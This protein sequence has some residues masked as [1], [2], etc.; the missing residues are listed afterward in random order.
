MNAM[1]QTLALLLV[2]SQPLAAMRSIHVQLTA[3]TPQSTQGG[4]SAAAMP[5]APSDEQLHQELRD[6]KAAMEQALNRRDVDALLAHVDERVVFTTMN[7][8]VVT[9]RDGVR[10]YF[11]R[12]MNGP[13]KIVE[14]VQ[15]SFVPD[16]L[17]V[18]HGGDMA[19]SW[20]RTAD[21]YELATGQS[22][23]IAARW[24]ATMVRREGRW[25]VANFH[26]STNMFDNPVLSGQRKLLIGG[27][28]AAALIL[29]IVGF[30]LGRRRT[31]G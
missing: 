31:G 15:A 21:Q 2:M 23:A 1:V 14:S 3:A 30:L 16:T 11:D 22:L 27:G 29:G 13:G 28:V 24:S 9:G 10:A 18:L 12:M 19:V 26:Y 8:D 4:A 20:G 7:G 6:L 5:S 25:L 17:S